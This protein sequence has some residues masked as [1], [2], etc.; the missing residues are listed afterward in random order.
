MGWIGIVQT[1]PLYP[2]DICHLLN[3]F[4]NMLLAIDV[5]TIIRQFLSNHVELLGAL[6]HQITHLIQDLL[7]RTTLVLTGN[8]RNST[9]GTMP[10]APFRNLHI[11]IMIRGRDLTMNI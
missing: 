2:F 1:N 3:Q 6:T 10:V 7:H 8:Q 5:H 9:I 4:C 11:N